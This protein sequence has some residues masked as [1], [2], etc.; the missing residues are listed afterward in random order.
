[1]LTVP[2]VNGSIQLLLAR[3]LNLTQ[4]SSVAADQVADSLQAL[5]S[6]LH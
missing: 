2:I 4:Y 3:A 1:M 5:V 6:K